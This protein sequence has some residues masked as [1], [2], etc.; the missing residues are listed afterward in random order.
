MAAGDRLFYFPTTSVYGK[1][2]TYSLTYESVHFSNGDDNMLHGWFFPAVGDATGTIVHCHGNAGNVTGHF[3]HVKWLPAEG[4][5]VFCFDYRGYG[6]STGAPTRA[7]TIRDAQA[8]IDHVRN[9]PDVDPDRIAVLGQSLGGA[10][11]IVVAA[12]REDLCGIAVEGAFSAYRTE[13]AFVCKQN[14]FMAPVAHWLARA[15]IASADDPIDWVSRIAPTPTLFVCG[16]SDGI[17]DHRQTIALHDAAGLPKSLWVIDGGGHTDAMCS[18]EGRARFL[19]FFE[20]CVATGKTP[21][22]DPSPADQSS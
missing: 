1:P 16:T 17:V 12:Q 6:R 13:A 21:Q 8:A 22:H 3:E 15:L 4:W 19:A 20:S 10:I 11:G 2:E 7:G 5:N 9:R 18:P 14:V